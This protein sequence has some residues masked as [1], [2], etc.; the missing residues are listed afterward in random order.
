M[1][2]IDEITLN[3][4]DALFNGTA[5]VEI[6]KSCIPSI[7][8]PWR[9]SGV[10]LDTALVAIKAAAGGNDMDVE[11]ICPSCDEPATY[12]V[13]LVGL[14]SSIKSGDYLTELSV[15]DL[16]IKF[17]PLTFKELTE[18]GLGQFEL[19]KMFVTINAIENITEKT[20]KQ[21][22]ALKMITE[23][24]IKVLSKAIEYI[25][26]PSSYVNQNEFILDF[27]TNCDKNMFDLIRKHHTDLKSQSEVKPLHVKCTHCQHEYDQE[28]SINAADFFG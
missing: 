3:T 14:L 22:E 20:A 27:L 13:N 23:I 21:R 15:N 16:L 9:L 1:T 25:K 2:A 11:T 6:I 12:A 26:T 28:F 7:K 17:R 5:V 4:P 19:Q 10:D 18:I 8:D 24:T